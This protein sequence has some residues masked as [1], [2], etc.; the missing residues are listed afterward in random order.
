MCLWDM[1]KEKVM[2]GS[3]YLQIASDTA[4]SLPVTLLDIVT[5][6][7]FYD[8]LCMIALSGGGWC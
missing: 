1:T 6:S 4:L 7:T 2:L 3:K 5:A 8:I